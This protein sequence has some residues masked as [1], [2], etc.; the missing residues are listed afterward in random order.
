M[1]HMTQHFGAVVAVIL[2]TACGSSADAQTRSE[3]LT[4]I[5]VDEI[6][7]HLR[8]AA[9]DY[10][11]PDIATKLQAEIDE[12]RAEYR[13]IGDPTQLATRLTADMRAVGHDFHLAVSYGEELG[14]R[15]EPTPEEKQ[16]AHAF[17]LA[18]GYGLRSARRLP[19]NIGYIDLAYFSPDPDAGTAVAAAMQLVNGTDA[20][21]LDLRRNGGGSGETEMTLISYFF[22]GQ[23]S[24]VEERVQGRLQERQHWTVPYVQGPRYTSKPVYILTSPHTHSAA[25][26]LAYDLK[27]ARVATIVGEHTSGEATSASGEIDLGH[28]FSAFIANGQIMSPVTHAN[29]IRTGVQPDVPA[30]PTNALETAYVLALKAAKSGV[31]SAELRKEKE[32]AISDTRAALR[33]EIDGFLQE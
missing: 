22:D 19:G 20:L 10:V 12:H 8:S 6:V 14:V 28:G 13:T 11:F 17:D 1:K 24:S 26:V 29:Y 32:S 23:L 30:E 18:S 7:D 3:R 25:E 2:L 15:K 31:D 33:Q 21:I 5:Q 16:H 4:P 27:N 9:Q